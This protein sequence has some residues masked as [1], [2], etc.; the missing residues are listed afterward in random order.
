MRKS[1]VLFVCCLLLHLVHV[2]AQKPCTVDFPVPADT[3]AL[4]KG[5][6][7]YTGR[8]L[9][10]VPQGGKHVRQVAILLPKLV[11]NTD[12]DG[13]L[14]PG[15]QNPVIN[16]TITS[17]QT[18]GPNHT[19]Q[20]FDVTYNNTAFRHNTELKLTAGVYDGKPVDY[21]YYCDYIIVAKQAK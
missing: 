4:G 10:C 13:V 7:M 17:P 9:M 6:Y 18:P 14:I 1:L 21:D 11:V 16:V 20:L 19:M 12:K 2:G 8:V 3:I 15:K 5:M